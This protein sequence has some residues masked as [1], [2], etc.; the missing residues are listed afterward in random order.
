MKPVNIKPTKQL[1]ITDL[2]SFKTT[3]WQ[4][5]VSLKD[6][7]EFIKSTQDKE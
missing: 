1:C 7:E 6:P 2:L 5:T 4:T 3:G